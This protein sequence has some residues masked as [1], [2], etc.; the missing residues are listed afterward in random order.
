MPRKAAVARLGGAP[1]DTISI[2]VRSHASGSR[3]TGSSA[4]T[5]QNVATAAR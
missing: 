3:S 1:T 4:V 5:A 2:A